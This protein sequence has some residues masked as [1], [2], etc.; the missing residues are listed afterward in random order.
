MCVYMYAPM[1]IDVDTCWNRLEL[2]S[3][4]LRIH[5]CVLYYI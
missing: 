1:Y 2:V 4:S 5:V 3:A